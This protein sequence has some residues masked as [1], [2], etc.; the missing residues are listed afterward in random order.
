MLRKSKHKTVLVANLNGEQ[1]VFLVRK[2]YKTAL[3]CYIDDMVNEYLDIIPP[4]SLKDFII[5][6]IIKMQGG[7]DRNT[8]RNRCI[9]CCGG[10]VKWKSQY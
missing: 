6:S 5:D 4:Q 1:V 10:G 7:M 9:R 2:K 8:C 3:K